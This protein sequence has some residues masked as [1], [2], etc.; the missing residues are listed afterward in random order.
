MY[1]KGESFINIKAGNEIV[2]KNEKAK[3]RER[4]Q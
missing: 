2:Q 1:G 3:D 4:E